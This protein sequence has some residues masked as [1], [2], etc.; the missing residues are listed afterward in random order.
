MI[1]LSLV[2]ILMNLYY[3]FNYRKLDKKFSERDKNSK[4]DLVYYI[5]KL[6]SWV[7]IIIGLFLQNNILFILLLTMGLLRIPIYHI[8][9]NWSSICYRLTPPIHIII[10]LIM[11]FT[12]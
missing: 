12:H 5:L 7:W 11:L 1:Y 10:M 3:L 6:F 2:F 4:L 8:N 9:P